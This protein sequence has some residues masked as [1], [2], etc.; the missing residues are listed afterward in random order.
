MEGASV[1]FTLHEKENASYFQLNNFFLKLIFSKGNVANIG[2]CPLL[3]TH[4]LDKRITISRMG[5][6]CYHTHILQV[7]SCVIK[8]GYLSNI[9]FTLEREFGPLS[10]KEIISEDVFLLK[11]CSKNGFWPATKHTHFT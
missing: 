11:K 7:R 10:I 2:S 4:I 9:Y 3:N 1:R 5:L 8:E 6:V